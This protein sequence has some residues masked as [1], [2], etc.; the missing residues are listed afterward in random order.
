M[1]TLRC[2]IC[3][4]TGH[5]DDWYHLYDNLIIEVCPHCEGARTAACFHDPTV[6]DDTA[7]QETTPTED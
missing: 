1:P 2:D 7:D 6:D 4:H 3:G 5:D